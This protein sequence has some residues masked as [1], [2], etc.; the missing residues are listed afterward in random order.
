MKVIVKLKDKISSTAFY[1]AYLQILSLKHYNWLIVLFDILFIFSVYVIL[2]T[3]GL[4]FNLTTF[5][6][7]RQSLGLFTNYLLILSMLIYVALLLFSVTFFRYSIVDVINNKLKTKLD[8]KRVFKLYLLNLSIFLIFFTFITI[9]INILL[10]AL[11]ADFYPY[12]RDAITVLTILVC[13]LAYNFIVAEFFI[14][15]QLKIVERVKDVFKIIFSMIL[16]KLS[17]LYIT[18][19]IFLGIFIILYF[20]SNTIMAFTLFRD[21]NIYLKYYPLYIDIFAW[22]AYIFVYLAIYFNRFYVI[23]IRKKTR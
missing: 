20:I 12:F 5:T 16:L 11:R 9:T 23:G 21:S 19:I 15:K 3:A 1:S 2:S 13:Y 14:S 7:V 10:F 8:L 18:F 17:A 4:F 22:I 6:L